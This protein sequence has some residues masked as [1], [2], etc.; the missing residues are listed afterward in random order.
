MDVS[1]LLPTLVQRSSV[2]VGLLQNVETQL[3]AVPGLKWEIVIHADVGEKSLGRKRCELVEAARGHYSVFLDDDDGIAPDFVNVY[4]GMWLSREYDVGELHGAY[5]DK[6]VFQ[7]RVHYSLGYARYLVWTTTHEAYIRPPCHLTPMRTELFKQ[8]GWPDITS[9]EDYHFVQRLQTLVRSNK[10]PLKEFHVLCEHPLYHYFD[11]V[12]DTRH[13][14]Q[15][16]WLPEQGFFRLQEA[17]EAKL[18]PVASGLYV[19][20]SSGLVN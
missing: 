13:R 14:L 15:P 4:K 19:Y 17:E 12:K 6:G 3:R 1:V 18:S 11:G 5:Y 8:I 7:K 9:R 10:A 2:L 16:V 20:S